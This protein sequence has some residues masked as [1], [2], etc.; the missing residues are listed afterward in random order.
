[1]RSCSGVVLLLLVMWVGCDGRAVYTPA[2]WITIKAGT[3]TMGSPST[4]K[5]R[6][7]GNFKETPHKVTLTH[8]F[9]ISDSETT[10]G[11]YENEMGTN[12]AHFVECGSDCPVDAVTWH[13]AVAYC[14]AL[15]RADTLAVC[16]QCSP[17]CTEATTFEGAQIYN[18]PGYR[19][20]TEAEWEYATR[21][22]TTSA[23]YSGSVINCTDYDANANTIGW[24]F[25]NSGMTLHE[26]RQ[27]A[28]NKW[29]LYDMPGS[30]W[31]W[32][33]DW[34]EADLGSAAVTDPAGPVQP[35]IGRVLRGGSAQVKP[36]FMRSA[37]RWN[38]QPP[39][40][41]LKLHGFRCVRTVK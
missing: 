28:P 7:A 24:Y 35:T 5:C 17:D 31:E 36:Q 27:K 25:A 4:E 30:V 33:H 3:F 23:Y 26:T 29:G 11:Q 12:P 8:S 10:Q 9:T 1:M 15:S 2:E 19:L 38:Y 34:F 41:Q 39:D 32:V 22:G 13:Q 16:Y 37:S 14:N 6:E 18:C 21:A 40:S 20:P